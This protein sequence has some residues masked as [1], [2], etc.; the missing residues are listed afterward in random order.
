RVR[1]TN[2]SKWF[3]AK[4]C[5]AYLVNI[6]RRSDAGIWEPTVY[7]ESQQLAW[8]ARGSGRHDAMD[9]PCGVPHFVDVFSVRD[10]STEFLPAI[11]ER[12]YRYVDL[13]STPGTYKFTVLVSGDGVRPESITLVL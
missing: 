7:A 2:K 5:R 9:L 10:A 11:P 6:E 3:V 13:Y 12:L 1:V 8:S 4:G